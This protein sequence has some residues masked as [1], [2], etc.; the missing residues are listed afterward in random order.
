MFRFINILGLTLLL[1][2]PVLAADPQPAPQKYVPFEVT[3][4]EYASLAQFLA[5]KPCNVACPI[6]QYL[7]AKEADALQKDGKK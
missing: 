6:M 2:S 7:N 5:D 4:Q 3:Q 1:A